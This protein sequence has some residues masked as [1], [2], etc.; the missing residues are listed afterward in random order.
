MLCCV[1]FQP[2]DEQSRPRSELT[3]FYR[4]VYVLHMMKE[5]PILLPIKIRFTVTVKQIVH[6]TAVRYIINHQQCFLP[7]LLKKTW[8][9]LNVRYRYVHSCIN[10]PCLHE[11]YCHSFVVLYYYVFYYVLF[12]V[13]CCVVRALV[14]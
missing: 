2:C 12:F 7:I 14:W 13:S 11:V 4:G 8:K 6:T 3:V 5:P 9:I 1:S 10:H